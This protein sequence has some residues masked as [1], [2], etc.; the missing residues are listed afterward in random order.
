MIIDED[1]EI[2]FHNVTIV[3]P[4]GMCVDDAKDAYTRLCNAL[5]ALGAEFTTDTYSTTGDGQVTDA[6]TEDLFPK[7]DDAQSHV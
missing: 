4:L 5:A 1:N 2:T 7:D 3:M 6:S